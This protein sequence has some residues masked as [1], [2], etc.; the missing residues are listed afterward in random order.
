MKKCFL[1]TE[2]LLWTILLL[3]ISENRY[4]KKKLILK[5]IIYLLFILRNKNY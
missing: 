1:R 2:I 5:L 4:K 3:G